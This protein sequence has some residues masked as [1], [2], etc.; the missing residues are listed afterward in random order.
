MAC[1]LV[2]C[3]LAAIS[4]FVMHEPI[5]DWFELF[6]YFFDGVGSDPESEGSHPM[7]QN[8]VR[9]A[10]GGEISIDIAEENDTDVPIA[11]ER[12][13]VVLKTYKF[14]HP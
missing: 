14:R 9:R 8:R 4:T 7:Q 11:E 1:P 3:A 6:L 12:D 5:L 2:Y 13:S 10:L